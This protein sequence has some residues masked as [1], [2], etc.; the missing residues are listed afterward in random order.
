[1]GR[2]A[3]LFSLQ[4]ASGVRHHRPKHR[5]QRVTDAK[6]VKLL[7]KAH[8]WFGDLSMGKVNSLQEIADREQ[9]DRQYVSRIIQLVFLAPDIVRTILSG[10]QPEPLTV[11]KLVRS[12]PL[13]VSWKAQRSMLGFD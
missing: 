5:V 6:L 7:S 13:P 12:V 1:M 3:G 2:G 10:K 11:D 9:L 4:E 8:Q